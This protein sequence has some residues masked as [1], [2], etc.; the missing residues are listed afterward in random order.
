MPEVDPNFDISRICACHGHSLELPQIANLWSVQTFILCSG[1]SH[2][3]IGICMSFVSLHEPS[4]SPVGTKLPFGLFERMYTM[5][6]KRKF[7]AASTNVGIWHIA[8]AGAVSLRST[9]GS[10]GP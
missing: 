5:G 7:V 2:T 10:K 4:M 8:E 3:G 9:L 6:S 1:H